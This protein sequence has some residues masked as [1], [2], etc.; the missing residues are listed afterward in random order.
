MD[1]FPRNTCGRCGGSRCLAPC[2]CLA[3]QPNGRIIKILLAP[4]EIWPFFN[5]K[6]IIF[7]PAIF[8]MLIF[9]EDMLSFSD[10]VT[11]SFC[12]YA[13][14]STAYP[15]FREVP[16]NHFEVAWYFSLCNQPTYF[17]P[18]YHNFGRPHLK[19]GLVKETFQE[20]P[21]LT[22][23]LYS[24]YSLGGGFQNFVFSTL[25]WEMI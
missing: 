17:W 5:S 15:V 21:E 4:E 8:S 9:R 23:A 24:I 18:N 7:Q 20:W 12:W 13:M 11:A 3:W 14:L 2:S 25:P 19:C 10:S 6:R 22:S 1:F 16:G